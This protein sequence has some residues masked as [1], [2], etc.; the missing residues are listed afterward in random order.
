VNNTV[1]L[2]GQIPLDPESMELVEGGIE[3]EINQVFNNLAAVCQAAGGDLKNIVKLNVYL[4]DL[5]NFSIVNTIMASHF[6]EPYPARAAI[7][8]SQ[9]PKEAE[10]EMDAI[11]VI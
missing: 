8:I 3:S 10:V 2:S 1:Y 11:M 5:A 9:L 6:E 7:G 4:T